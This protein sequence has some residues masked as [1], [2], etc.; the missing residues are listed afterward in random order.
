MWQDSLNGIFELAGGAFILISCV[1]LIG[2]KKVRGVS[3]IHVGYFSLW[4]YW[5]LYYYSN[6]GQWVSLIGS[7]SVTLV[8]TMWLGLIVYYL[9]KERKAKNG[10]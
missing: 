9:K 10:R 8:N 3:F 1:K 6:L 7:L 4:G 5:N 2:D